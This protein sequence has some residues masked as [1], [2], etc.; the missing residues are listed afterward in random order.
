MKAREFLEWLGFCQIRC[1][2]CGV[3]Y[4]ESDLEN[5]ERLV[6]PRLCPA[7]Q[8]ILEAY[9][10]PACRGCGL[11]ASLNL[12]GFCGQ[13][14]VA[15]PPWAAIAFHGLYEGVLRELV[16]R[17]KFGSELHLAALFG[18]FLYEA[19]KCLPR[20]DAI[21]AIP[22]FPKDL[23]KRGFNQAHEI[24]RALARL[25]GFRLEDRLLARARHVRPQEGLDAARR[26][27]NV[28]NI[29]VAS[30]AVAGKTIWL[31]DDVLTTGATCASAAEE[32]LRAGANAVC[33]VCAART[34]L[35]P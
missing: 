10:G 31:L 33:A 1:A 28:K 23:R 22:A 19:C 11:P 24:A 14:A 4:F 34:P 12:A 17:L 20:P 2:S 18:Q 8:K 27:L 32:L 16:L 29:F 35:R 26:K 6:S 3:P 21:I 25:G 15:P 5:T 9:A 13:C 7:C 30:A